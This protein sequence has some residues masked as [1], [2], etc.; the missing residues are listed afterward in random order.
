MCCG[1]REQMTEVTTGYRKYTEIFKN[2]CHS[3]LANGCKAF[4]QDCKIVLYWANVIRIKT[5]QG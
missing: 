3:C 2:L 1:Q 4:V 5:K